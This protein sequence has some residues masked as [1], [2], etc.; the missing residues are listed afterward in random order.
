M[1]VWLTAR[2]TVGSRPSE[3]TTEGVCG[4]GFMSHVGFTMV[5]CRRFAARLLTGK[6]WKS[7]T[8][9]WY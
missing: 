9:L 8:V 3:R 4:N 6:T 7:R 1:Y 2:S 5:L